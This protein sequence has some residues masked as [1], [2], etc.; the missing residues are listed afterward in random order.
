MECPELLISLGA[1]ACIGIGYGE[2]PDQASSFGLS[3]RSE[4]RCPSFALGETSLANPQCLPAV[5]H[6]AENGLKAHQ[7]SLK[8]RGR[9]E[10]FRRFQIAGV[11]G[12]N[13]LSVDLYRE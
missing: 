12:Q 8:L 11:K 3:I 4:D 9:G 7:V 5:P 1:A 10:L 6:A 2:E 13:A